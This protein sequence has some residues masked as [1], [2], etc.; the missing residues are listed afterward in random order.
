MV[1]VC[2]PV[3]GIRMK[4]KRQQHVWEPPC[5]YD[6]GPSYLPLCAYGYVWVSYV[7]HMWCGVQCTCECARVYE[8]NSIFLLF[9]YTLF[10]V[11]LS[12]KSWWRLRNVPILQKNIVAVVVVPTNTGTQFIAY[13]EIVS[14]VVVGVAANY[15][16]ISFFSAHKS[17]GSQKIIFVRRI[18]F[19]LA[20]QLNT[21]SLQSKTPH[22][23]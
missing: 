16:Y 6:R 19:G 9:F 1:P 17:I 23:F 22:S 12:L 11:C 15:H 18:S 14:V 20:V 10:D 5:I 21:C 13:T 2:R 7:V 8:C 4:K 3:C